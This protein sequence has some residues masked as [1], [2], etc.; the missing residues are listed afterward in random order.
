M[1]SPTLLFMSRSHGRSL[2]ENRDLRGTVG[3]D[4]EYIVD[5]GAVRTYRQELTTEQGDIRL[6]R[7]KT[8]S[9]AVTDCWEPVIPQ[10]ASAPGPVARMT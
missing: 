3:D 10:Q 4:G 7:R 9:P 2:L 8:T 5:D 6:L 1:R